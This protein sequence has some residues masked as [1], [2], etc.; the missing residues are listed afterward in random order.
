MNPPLI[1]KQA[2]IMPALFALARRGDK[3]ELSE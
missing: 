1:H 3:I 2:Y